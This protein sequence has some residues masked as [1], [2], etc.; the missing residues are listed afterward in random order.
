LDFIKIDVEN[1]EPAVIR[2]AASAI[3]QFQPAIVFE[4][5]H[6]EEN[7]EDRE[8]IRNTLEPLGYRVVGILIEHGIVEANWDSYLAFEYPFTNEL[9]CDIL[10]FPSRKER[11]SQ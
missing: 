1:H 10:C 4:A 6:W 7:S 8:S 5:G 9:Y 2:G 11:R 3:S